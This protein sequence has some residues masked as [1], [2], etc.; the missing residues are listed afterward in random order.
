LTAAFR[1]I[2][3][4]PWKAGAESACDNSAETVMDCI[5][6]KSVI[7][8]MVRFFIPPPQKEN[9]MV[10]ASTRN[11]VNSSLSEPGLILSVILR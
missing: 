8:N 3:A 7:D 11:K 6:A 1:F 4:G 10:V 9:G 2:S 5:A